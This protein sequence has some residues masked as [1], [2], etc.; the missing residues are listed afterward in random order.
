MGRPASR[1]DPDAGAGEAVRLEVRV[2]SGEALGGELLLV[3]G[4]PRVPIK[5]PPEGMIMCGAYGQ[6]PAAETVTGRVY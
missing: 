1:G 4:A 5:I 3:G 6:P 2:L